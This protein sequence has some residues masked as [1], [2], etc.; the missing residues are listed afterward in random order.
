MSVYTIDIDFLDGVGFVDYS[1]FMI[2]E[3]AVNE[4]LHNKYKATTN[5]LNVNFRKNLELLS[6]L[7][8]S[9]GKAYANIG[10]DGNP[11][12]TGVIRTDGSFSVTSDVNEIS[13]EILDYSYLLKKK[14][15]EGYIYRNWKLCDPSDT[16]N[17]LI[18]SVLIKAGFTLPHLA[19]LTTLNKIIPLFELEE[20]KE[21]FKLLDDLLFEY[22]YTFLFDNSGRFNLIDLAPNTVNIEHTF[23]DDSPEAINVIQPLEVDK[24][25]E[26]NV[27]AHVEWYET[28][29]RDNTLLY[30]GI[31]DPE[32]PVSIPY[33]LYYPVDGKVK[34]VYQRFKPVVPEL[35]ET[36][37]ILHTGNHYLNYITEDP[38]IVVDTESYENKRARIVFHNT[39]ST[40]NFNLE[41]FDIRGTL[42]YKSTEHECFVDGYGGEEFYETYS[43]KY[44]NTE[45]DAI[46]LVNVLHDRLQF[47]IMSYSFSSRDNVSVG[48]IA[49]LT[50][51]KSGINTTI[52]IIEKSFNTR[53]GIY[54]YVAEGLT[55]YAEKNITD[56]AFSPSLAEPINYEVPEPNF[57]VTR[58]TQPITIDRGIKPQ[59]ISEDKIVFMNYDDSN[60][61]YR[62][63]YKRLTEG[64]KIF[65]QS[66]T[67]FSVHDN[68]TLL[69]T[70]NDG[71][72]ERLNIDTSATMAIT[73]AVGS[74]P[75][76]YN[77]TQFVYINAD[78]GNTLW[79]ASV[80]DS[81]SGSQLVNKTI[82]DYVVIDADRIAY[83]TVNGGIIYLYTISTDTEIPITTNNTGTELFYDPI[84][85]D[86]LYYLNPLDYTLYK[87]RIDDAN[88][89]DALY[90]G[91]LSYTFDSDFNL[92]FTENGVDQ[93]LKL[94]W[95]NNTEEI[96]SIDII[97]PTAD[98]TFYGDIESY[99]NRIANYSAEAFGITNI[100]DTISGVGIPEDTTVTLV[101]EN[102]IYLS[103]QATATLFNT[104]LY[105]NSNKVLIGTES[106]LPGSITEV[107][108]TD[109]AI[110]AP[111]IKANAI[112][113]DKLDAN[114][115]FTMNLRSQNYQEGVSGFDL[116]KEGN[117]E[118]NNVVAR[119]HI[120]AETG[121]FNGEVYA[122]KGIFNGAINADSGIFRGYIDTASLKT[123]EG[124]ETIYG[125]W[126]VPAGTEQARTLFQYIVCGAGLN[127][128]TFYRI[129]TTDYP[130]A[131]YVYCTKYA[132][133]IGPYK[134]LVGWI[135]RLF[136]NTY[137]LI[138]EAQV[139]IEYDPTNHPERA[140]DCYTGTAKGYWD[141]D[142]LYNFGQSI[143]LDIVRGGD[144][145]YL[146]N[147]PDSADGLEQWRVWR[148]IDALKIKT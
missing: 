11:F 40:T 105:L 108:I 69:Y 113:A 6:R 128:D 109:N 16:D 68:N 112:T 120:E 117:A 102:Y 93:Y 21:Y 90:T 97:A 99:D 54:T 126:T 32:Q 48:T 59:I 64:Y 107:K 22:G 33:G 34:D 146:L 92:I 13:L 41:W 84:N 55:A 24:T 26:D 110:T 15:K 27:T 135:V 136:D 147:L 14:I 123:E 111:K 115:I 38:A 35:E 67:D 74:K 82:Y 2:N 133:G 118:L 20:K 122:D 139:V 132:R 80:N 58:P 10:K 104:R 79:V 114:A 62:K 18:H 7:L 73:T 63:N 61:L 121:I 4:K 28:E 49:N 142:Y 51:V 50:D 119:G 88:D 65:D 43:A 125:P 86:F 12:F 23:S 101:D 60:K 3:L 57:S 137:T 98:V 1:E 96:N 37:K 144:K 138:D 89:G 131:S 42:L 46:K 47:G 148:D 87:T 9:E 52:R 56:I 45:E 127:K 44:I 71:N 134:A 116:N 70:D 83:T 91:I 141:G 94:R 5:T 145:L 81:L 8:A 143:T 95:S 66:V 29:E 19:N 124:S 76:K 25:D 78:D 36:P 75:K 106:L 17:S 100:G 103:N 129:G 130:N 140:D 77:G 85:T 72:I 53:D 30:R 31:P 39:S